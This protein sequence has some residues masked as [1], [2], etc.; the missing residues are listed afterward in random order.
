MRHLLHMP[1]Q[2]QHS[3]T[4]ST[5]SSRNQG[6]PADE[7][8]YVW[9]VAAVGSRRA[10]QP[11]EL[12][13]ELLQQMVAGTGS[14]SSTSSTSGSS[15]ATSVQPQGMPAGNSHQGT[16][17][18]VSG[19]MVAPDGTSNGGPWGLELPALTAHWPASPSCNFPSHGGHTTAI[20]LVTVMQQ[21]PEGSCAEADS[22][23]HSDATCSSSSGCGTGGEATFVFTS[24]QLASSA[25]TA[26]GLAPEVQAAVQAGAE[27]DGSQASAMGQSPPLLKV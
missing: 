25:A 20:Q 24:A 19:L 27:Q 8:P 11:A 2:E 3:S 14:T 22:I 21:V 17:H 7:L 12:M 10:A 1:Q 18:T 16:Q 13:Q 26:A 9:H 23:S 15:D 5:G 4:G 6:R